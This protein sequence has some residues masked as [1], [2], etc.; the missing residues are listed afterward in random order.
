MAADSKGA[1]YCLSEFAV[2]EV[3]RKRS[4]SALLDGEITSNAS[5]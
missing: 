3:F 4:T 1:M 2:L 5:L